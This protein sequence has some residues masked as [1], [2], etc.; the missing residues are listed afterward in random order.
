[1]MSHKKL[2]YVSVKCR[3]K[4]SSNEYYSLEGFC[5]DIVESLIGTLL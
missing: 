5:Q 1:M 4:K 3:F 2:L